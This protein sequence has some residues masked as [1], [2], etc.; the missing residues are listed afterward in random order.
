ML[1]EIKDYVIALI[2]VLSSA[3][4]SVVVK[5]LTSKIN[6]VSKTY[7]EK[8]INCREDQET[9]MKAVQECTANTNRILEENYKLVEE[10]R[11]L[12]CLLANVKQEE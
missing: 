10:N 8:L 2:P 12:K 4:I 6:N 7:E 1:A 3:L 9:I 11:K 5:V